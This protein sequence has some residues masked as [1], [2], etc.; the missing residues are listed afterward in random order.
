MRK[1][2]PQVISGDLDGLRQALSYCRLKATPLLF[3]LT[4]SN[5]LPTALRIAQ[6]ASVAAN[7]TVS[8]LLTPKPIRGEIE[9]IDAFFTENGEMRDELEETV[10][11]APKPKKILTP[12][13]KRERA[14]K[15]RRDYYAQH[16]EELKKAMRARYFAKKAEVK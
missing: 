2:I 7:P 15:Y 5:D 10:A 12:E 16:K 14:A 3:T 11:A 6:D 9:P 13:Q 8:L 1:D 4:T